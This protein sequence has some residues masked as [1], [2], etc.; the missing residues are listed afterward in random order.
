MP[1][2]EY[3]CNYCG[4][5]FEINQSIKEN[6]QKKCPDCNKLGLERLLFSPSVFVKGEPST[7][8][9]LA[10]RNSKKIG[11][12]TIQEREAIYAEKTGLKK[13]KEKKELHQRINKMTASQKR[14][15]IED[16]K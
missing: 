16:G 5:Q 10:D 12:D 13:N 14:R 4:L 6:A 2:Y 11:K 9:Q 1:I 3:V 8:G 15:F 7:I